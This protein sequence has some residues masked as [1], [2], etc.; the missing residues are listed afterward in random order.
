MTSRLGVKVIFGETALA[1]VGAG[2][3]DPCSSRGLL[4][5]G[6]RAVYG[7]GNTLSSGAK[8]EGTELPDPRAG[9]LPPLAGGGGG[10]PVP[11]TAPPGTS[12]SG[13]SGGMTILPSKIP[14]SLNK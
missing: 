9:A 6:S 1:L 13:V 4:R 5:E 14:R 11:L 7:L 2:P 8:G 10:V 3:T 12:D